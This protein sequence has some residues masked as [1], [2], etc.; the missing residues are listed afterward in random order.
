MKV[1]V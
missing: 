1:C